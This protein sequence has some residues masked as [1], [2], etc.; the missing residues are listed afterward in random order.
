MRLA[1]MPS[2]F[3]LLFATLVGCSSST[4]PERPIRVAV[5]NELDMELTLRAGTTVLGTL[6]GYDSVSVT[7]PA[8][9][10]SL[11]WESQKRKYSD[12]SPMMDD[13]TG[14]T[15]SVS[16]TTSLVTIT[17]VVNGVR[18]FTP[19]TSIGLSDTLSFEIARAGS[20]MC[21]GNAVGPTLVLGGFRFGI[22]W[23]YYRLTEDT[24]LRYYRGSRCR[25]GAAPYRFWS[26]SALSTA[27]I[28]SGRVYLWADV[29]P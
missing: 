18:Y 9:V 5:V 1:I 28:G 21:L 19:E 15:V 20:T 16:A 12:E 23:G 14:A 24:Q 8:G 2:P 7:L 10:R 13:L 17:N 6:G 3:A 27:A 25:E 4:E 22:N 29:L 11:V 26:F